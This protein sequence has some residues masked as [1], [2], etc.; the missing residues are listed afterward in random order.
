MQAYQY[1]LARSQRN[2]I[3]LAV[4]TWTFLKQAAYRTQQTVYQLKQGFW[5]CAWDIN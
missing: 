4:W 3:A 1:R 2:H 5:M